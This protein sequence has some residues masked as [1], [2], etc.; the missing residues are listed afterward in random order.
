[1]IDDGGWRMKVAELMVG[2]VIACSPDDMLNRAAQ[3]MWENDCGCVPVVDRAARLVAMLT[4]RDVCMA[5]YTR[6]GTLKDIRVSA[7]MSN[8]LFACRPDDDLPSAMKM[9]RDRQ[10]R[11]IPVSDDK[12]RLVGV[13]SL[14]DVARAI[15][16][17]A[18]TKAAAADTLV[19][20]CS[21]HSHADKPQTNGRHNVTASNHGASELT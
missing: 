15:A 20:V 1:M 2:E 3:I 4:D 14:N 18:V 12:G 16:R 7:A 5:A 21:P 10:V 6:G 17:K 8:E 19:K 9:M 11:R 13:L